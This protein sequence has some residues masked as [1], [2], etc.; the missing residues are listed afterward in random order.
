MK[1]AS[2]HDD[3]TK[4]NN[5]SLNMALLACSVKSI[6]D[7]SLKNYFVNI[8]IENYQRRSIKQKTLTM[9]APEI[10]KDVRPK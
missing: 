6:H 1:I 5:N 4:E 2:C 8:C 7:M 3:V 9:H 10:T